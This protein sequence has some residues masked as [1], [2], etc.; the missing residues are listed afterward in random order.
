VVGATSQ[1]YLTD[2]DFATAIRA[3][4]GANN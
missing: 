2:G 1:D 4:V 3:V